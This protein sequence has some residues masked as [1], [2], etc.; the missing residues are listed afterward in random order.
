MKIEAV[1]VHPLLRRARRNT[2]TP[3]LTWP[4]LSETRLRVSERLATWA[5]SHKQAVATI[6]AAEPEP[7][8]RAAG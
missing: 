5:G 7:P 1:E 4:R 6:A 3:M 2:D 8:K